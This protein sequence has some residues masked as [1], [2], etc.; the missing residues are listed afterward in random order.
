M[1]EHD[2]YFEG[3]SSETDD[4]A[5]NIIVMMHAKKAFNITARAHV[6]RVKLFV[7]P[8]VELRLKADEWK[9]ACSIQASY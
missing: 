2:F 3:T 7:N 5:K 4:S 1:L 6:E 8:V 9:K